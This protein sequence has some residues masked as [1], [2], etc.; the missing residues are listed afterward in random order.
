MPDRAASPEDL[1]LMLIRALR[2]SGDA[3]ESAA[4]LFDETAGAA[5]LRRA[6]EAQG[7]LQ[8]GNVLESDLVATGRILEEN[9]PPFDV[10]QGAEALGN[11]ARA[12]GLLGT[13]KMRD[14]LTKI[15][16]GSRREDTSYGAFE[17]DRI[18][19]RPDIRELAKRRLQGTPNRQLISTGALAEQLAQPSGSP[20]PAEFMTD[21]SLQPGQD[22]ADLL[23]EVHDVGRQANRSRTREFLEAGARLLHDDLARDAGQPAEA[24]GR[25]PFEEVLAW[26]SRR[27]VVAE[28]QRNWRPDASRARNEGPTE[29]AF[30][31]RWRAQADY[32][33]DV[34]TWTLSSRMKHPSQIR[35]AH[36]IV[37]TVRS[38]ERPL[39]EATHDIAAAE[40]QTLKQD[41]AFRLQMVFQATLAHDDQVADALRRIDMA[42]VDGWAEFARRSFDQ[43]G[44]TPRQD[45]DFALLGCALHAAGEGVMFRAM[46]PPKGG[47]ATPGPADLLDLITKALIIASA[48]PGDGKTL[49]EVL[50]ELS[51]RHRDRRGGQPDAPGSSSAG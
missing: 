11:V 40:V 51:E 32:L 19:T 26:L 4:P 15:A 38:G 14:A 27:R 12:E 18:A 42:N 16:D 46:A 34:V 48:D 3:L 45:V 5:Q 30:R 47:H 6:G 44:L 21:S 33:R 10:A 41:K 49:D 39:S 35:H 50:N 7:L 24:R 9:S 28:A 25:P 20:V 31:H 1:E 37:D 22:L 36:D 13:Q 29:A 8:P 23:S 2:E 43:L 17:V